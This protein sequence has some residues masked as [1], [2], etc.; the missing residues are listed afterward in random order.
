MTGLMAS[1]AGRE[2]WRRLLA[3]FTL[4]S[5]LGPIAALLAFRDSPDAFVPVASVLLLVAPVG[6]LAFTVLARA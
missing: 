6:A 1:V 3:L 5:V 4:L 2:A